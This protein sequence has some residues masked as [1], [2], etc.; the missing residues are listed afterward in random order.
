MAYDS[1]TGKI[2]APVSISDV[3]KCFGLSSG[4]L[5]TLIKNA[6]INMWARYKPVPLDDV[7]TVTGQWDK[8]NNKWLD[9]ATWYKGKDGM[10]GYEVELNSYLGNPSD[11]SSFLYKLEH[12]QL[13]FTYKKPSYAP[14]RLQD[15]AGYN[16]RA[17][18]PLAALAYGGRAI[19]VK[20]ATNVTI[21]YI[22]NNDDS[23]IQL[24]DF[25]Q[26]KYLAVFVRFASGSYEVVSSVTQIG[27]DGWNQIQITIPAENVGKAY[28][29][30]FISS[31]QLTSDNWQMQGT[32]SY[33]GYNEKISVG[34]FPF[35]DYLNVQSYYYDHHIIVIGNWTSRNNHAVIGIKVRVQ[36]SGKDDMI[37]KGGIHVSLITNS[38]TSISGEG[39]IYVAG[40]NYDKD[41]SVG[42]YQNVELPEDSDGYCMRISYQ[43]DNNH[44]YWLTA[45]FNDGTETDKVWVSVTD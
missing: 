24:Q 14:Y 23:S 12:K 25:R 16:H 2:T 45:Q 10:C 31:R 9:S 18:S 37:F 4:D 13:V 41:I 42:A 22:S 43:G 11:Q 6:N 26:G 32:Y 3:Q 33:F 39:G 5:V 44:S 1:S 19:F 21:T 38:P 15:F 40:A 28:I 36:N 27:Q 20:E 17:V 7:D 29:Y 34:S 35:Q 30:P 8:V